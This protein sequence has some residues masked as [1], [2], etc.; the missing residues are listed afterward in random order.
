V[1]FTDFLAEHSSSISL[2]KPFRLREHLTAIANMDVR[3]NLR[4]SNI[5]YKIR[6]IVN[7]T[8]RDTNDVVGPISMVRTLNV[9][10]HHRQ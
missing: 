10:K 7:A 2:V 5:E 6:R 3:K 8:Q 9:S 1:N 4:N